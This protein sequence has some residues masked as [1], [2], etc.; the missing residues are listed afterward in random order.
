MSGAPFMAEMPCTIESRMAALSEGMC[1]FGH[2]LEPISPKLTE[3]WNRGWREGTC[4]QCRPCTLYRWENRYG[5]CLRRRIH[6]VQPP[7][8]HS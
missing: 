1:P 5:Y 7:A 8:G 2:A 3:G 6:L 4:H